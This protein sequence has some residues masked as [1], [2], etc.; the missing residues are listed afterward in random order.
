MGSFYRS[1][2]SLKPLLN[3]QVS[4]SFKY[5]FKPGP[6]MQLL[7]SVFLMEKINPTYIYK[8]LGAILTLLFSV[9]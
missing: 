2:G 1:P 9:L 4:A 8:S 6:A 3:W 7:P 5:L